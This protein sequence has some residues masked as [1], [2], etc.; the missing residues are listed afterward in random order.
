MDSQLVPMIGQILRII[1]DIS[2]K[3]DRMSVGD[4]EEFINGEPTVMGRILVIAGSIGY[5]AT[6]LE[7][8]SLHQAISLV[9]FER[10][11]TLAI[12]ILLLESAH[13]EAATKINRELAGTS[14]IGGLVASEMCRRGVS[15]EA[16][17]AF[18]CGALRNYGRML[19]ATFLP[20]EYGGMSASSGKGRASQDEL[21]ASIFG[22]TSLE[23]GQRIMTNLQLPK[24][25]LNTMVQ[26]SPLDRR[27]CSGT[28]TSALS[29][30][31]DFGVRFAELLQIA[32]LDH[33]TFEH[34]A[35][36]LSREYDVDFHLTRDDVRD[37][38]HYLLSVLEGFRYRA[39]AYVGTVAMFRRLE[40]LAGG[41]VLTPALGAEIEPM[42]S[43]SRPTPPAPNVENYEI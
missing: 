14:L 35:E 32:E 19:A 21:F 41:R 36:S 22:L 1:R 5:N 6:G 10:V 2:G 20:K 23:L 4:L 7:I 3:S 39:G 17:L 16:E 18:I 38:L 28:A 8:T 26:L 12:S 29:G 43:S 25:I 15:S 11:R 40:R 27:H 24:P 33:Y 9:G 30:A 13:S 31:A 34:R 37:L 42:G